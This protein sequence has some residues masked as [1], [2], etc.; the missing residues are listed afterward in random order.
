MLAKRWRLPFG[1]VTLDISVTGNE[2][3]G[4]GSTQVA[5]T[6]QKLADITG[7]GN[8]GL[9]DKLLM[10]K[11]LNGLDTPGYVLRFFDLNGGGTVGLDDKLILNKILNGLPIQ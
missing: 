6:V 4:E 1:A 2:I 11:W 8:V 3:G 7:Q 9:E 5:L 10:N